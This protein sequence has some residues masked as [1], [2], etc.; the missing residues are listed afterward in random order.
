MTD[1]AHQQC[2]NPACAATYGVAE[3][4]VAC[5]KCG[6]LLDVRYDWDR[7]PVPKSLG[8]FEHRWNT[9]GTGMQGRLDFSGVWSFRE[10]M[11]FYRSEDDSDPS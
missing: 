6:S 7:L 4:H 8:F 11:P 10:L 2:I 9:K 3:T 5:A 1:R